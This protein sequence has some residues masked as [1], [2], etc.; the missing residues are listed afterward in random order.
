MNKYIQV[1][2]GAY[3]LNS[4]ILVRQLSNMLTV[5]TAWIHSNHTYL[6]QRLQ[7]SMQLYSLYYD[8]MRRR[9]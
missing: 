7:S 4:N 2:S 3:L 8:K 9:I 1:L 5:Q 6:H